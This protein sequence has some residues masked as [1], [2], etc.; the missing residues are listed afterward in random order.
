[1]HLVQLPVKPLPFYNNGSLGSFSFLLCIF[2]SFVLGATT[3]DRPSVVVPRSSLNLVSLKRGSIA[4]SLLSLSAHR[5]AMTEILLKMVQIR[6]DHPPVRSS[7]VRQS[8]ALNL[9]FFHTYLFLKTFVRV[10][11]IFVITSVFPIFFLSIFLSAS[12]RTF[13]VIIFV[14]S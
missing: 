10:L 9:S 8:S 7:I 12:L 14:G 1:M 4:N 11:I 3:S 6:V 5:L 2:F 13:T